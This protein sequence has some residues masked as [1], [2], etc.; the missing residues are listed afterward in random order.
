M[1]ATLFRGP[2]QP[3]GVETVDIDAPM[4]G[5]VLVRSAAVGV[6]HSDLHYF[7]G[8]RTLKAGVVILGHEPAG[9]VEKVGPE[10]S[11]AKVGDHVIAC[12]SLYC[13]TCAQCIQ[14]RPHL[15]ADRDACSRPD[16]APPRLS[17]D[18]EILPPEY[19]AVVPG[20]S[21]LSQREEIER[22]DHVALLSIRKDPQ[23]RHHGSH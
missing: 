21:D 6:C 13:R 14:G 20:D 10:V 22:K 5:E 1:R 17:L 4:A 7:D 3:S 11:R 16:D 23:Y 8:S 9:I 19:P 12:T 15:S 18:G 2:N